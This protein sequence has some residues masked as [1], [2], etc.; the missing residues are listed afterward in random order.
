LFYDFQVVHLYVRSDIQIPSDIVNKQVF[1]ENFV[2]KVQ[3]LFEF[4]LLPEVFRSIQI[5]V[6]PVLID[7]NS[8]Q[9][10]HPVET[11]FN[12][13]GLYTSMSDMKI[14]FKNAVWIT[15][16]R[17]NVQPMNQLQM[18]T[19]IITPANNFAADPFYE[20]SVNRR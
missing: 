6:T 14:P 4:Y 19:M 2:R 1:M 17:K 8:S 15:Q 20:F 10:I 7:A 18:S 12:L 13:P 11:Q 16:P 5:L 3:A 9:F